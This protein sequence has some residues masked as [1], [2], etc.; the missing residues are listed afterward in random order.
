[1]QQPSEPIA[2]VEEAMDVDE[3]DK[4]DSCAPVVDEAECVTAAAAAA[5]AELDEAETSQEAPS[6]SY[7]IPSQ[8]FDADGPS[9]SFLENRIAEA[10][11][12]D[13]SFPTQSYEVD[14]VEHISEALDTDAELSE[15][16]NLPSQSNDDGIG[17][18]SLTNSLGFN[19][20]ETASSSYVPE[21]PETQERDQDQE[22][23]I[24]TSSYEI[25]PCEDL[26][27][28]SSSV[29]PDTSEHMSIHDNGVPE[30]PTSSYNL[31]PDSSSTHRDAVPTSSFEDQV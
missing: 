18:S 23:A 24:S 31:N 27:I 12:A 3:V 15:E 6:Q 4:A 14:K 28:A 11:E 8:S 10:E 22:S 17:T 1:M 26:N 21:T 19:E 7:E 13:P 16:G 30:I 25:A 9:Q 2:A 20:D 29:I 5:V